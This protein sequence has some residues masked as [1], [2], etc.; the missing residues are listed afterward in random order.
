MVNSLDDCTIRDLVKYIRNKGQLRD[1]PIEAIETY[2][3]FENRRTE[4]TAL[5]TIFRGIFYR[6]LTFQN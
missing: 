3:V 6:E 2:F 5:A 1:T 4:Q